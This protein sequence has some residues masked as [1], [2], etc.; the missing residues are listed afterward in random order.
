MKKANLAIALLLAMV[1]I[2]C[3]CSGAAT[4]AE[5]ATTTTAAT[6]ASAAV[7]SSE[8]P[9][10]TT[11]E[12]E[13]K[14]AK[15]TEDM[16]GNAISVP[17]EIDKIITLAPSITQIAQS[18]GYS[19][20]I[21]GIDDYSGT[22]LLEPLDGV[23][24]FDMQSPDNET[25][26]TLEPDI[27]FVTG[28]NIKDGINPYQILIDSGICVAVIPSA[29]SLDGIKC[30]IQFIADC[31]GEPEKATAIIEK[32]NSDIETIKAIG[33]TITDKKR[34][35]FEISALPYLYSFGKGTFLDEMITLIGAENVY[36][37][38]EYWVAVTEEAAI[39]ANPDVILTSVYYIDDPEGEIKSRAGWE[40]VT[41][42]KNGDIHKFT[43]DQTDV[44]N[45]FVTE[46]LFEMAK[47]VYPDEYAGV[48]YKE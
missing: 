31:M 4:T 30:D 37:N 23:T 8:T 14:P 48:E 32:M 46:A 24:V 45:Q 17:E 2:L 34:I 13:I 5:T 20:M 18:M 7:S 40:A 21:V 1:L 12:A 33:E 44:P 38:E 39:A 6:T 11:T 26:L 10:A 28:M 22:Y 3:A 47:Y 15:P 43:S 35:H 41:A 29:D 25:I 27:I 9:E 16:D 42:I 19:E 36:A